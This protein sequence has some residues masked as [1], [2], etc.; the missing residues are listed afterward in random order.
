MRT[1]ISEQSTRA[2]GSVE[3][4]G[5]Y[6]GNARSC[7]LAQLLRRSQYKFVFSMGTNASRKRIL[8]IFFS[9]ATGYTT[10]SRVSDLR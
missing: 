7:I 10:R 9:T 6:D 2:D 8:E 5:I 3:R 4:S 1:P